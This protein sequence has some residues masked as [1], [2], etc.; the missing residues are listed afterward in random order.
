MKT[1]GLE[2][3]TYALCFVKYETY[4]YSRDSLTHLVRFVILHVHITHGMSTRP[5]GGQYDHGASDRYSK[6]TG[7]GNE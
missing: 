7:E 6:W 1:I 2:S 4:C 5:T 3:R